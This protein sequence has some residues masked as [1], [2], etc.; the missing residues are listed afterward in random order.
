MPDKNKHSSALQ[1]IRGGQIILHNL[2]MLSQVFQQLFLIAVLIFGLIFSGWYFG[3]VDEYS[4]YVTGEW[5]IAKMR[6]SL[7]MNGARKFQLPDGSVIE[8]NAY[9]VISAPKV[10]EIKD[11]LFNRAEKVFLI[12]LVLTILLLSLISYLLRTYGKQKT[13]STHI[14]GDKHG[15]AKDVRKLL[16][17][18]NMASPY[19]FGKDKLPL[20]K[21]TEMQHVLFAGSTGSGKSTAIRELLDHIRT[22]GEKVFIYD[23]GCSF[24]QNYFRP[25]EDI[26]LNPLD[27]RSSHWDF[28]GECPTKAHFENRAAALIPMPPNVSEPFFVVAARTIFSAAAHRMAV[29]TKKPSLLILLRNLLTADISELKALL[30]GTEAETLMS[31][32]IEKT[33]ISVKAMLATYLKSLCYL[34]EGENPF[35]IRKWV[36]NDN[37]KNWIFVSSVGDKHESLKPLITAWLDI[38]VN[39]LLSLTEDPDRRIWFIL[40]EITS[41]QQ[42]PYLN[43]ALAEARKF[44]GCFVIGLQNKALLESIY[45]VKGSTGILG[46]LNSRFFFREPEADLAEWVSRNL[47]SAIINEVKESISYGANTYRDGVSLNQHERTV[48]IVTPSEIMGLSP[49]HCFIRLTGHYPIT[50]LTFNYIQRERLQSAFISRLDEKNELLTEV[51][52]LCDKLSSPYLDQEKVDADKKNQQTHSVEKEDSHSIEHQIDV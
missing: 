18:T 25:N 43:S 32:K 16:I 28:W 21:Y 33:A 49:L 42:L 13:E 40:D 46:L 34:T 31:E 7:N 1:V 2:R 19:T 15:L 14:R 30:G 41:L 11:D 36:E 6:Y 38:A 8:T 12:D 51:M 23:K 9:E 52:S 48:P 22:R 5:M 37:Q 24:I 10:I 26:L 4:R 29:I 20:V 39:S 3:F 45:G 44:G 47:G 27:Q 50:Q 17:K 35:S